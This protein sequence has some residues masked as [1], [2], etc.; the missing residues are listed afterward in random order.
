MG[1]P[2]DPGLQHELW[3][4]LAVAADD[5]P[6][7]VE[8]LLTALEGSSDATVRDLLSRPKKKKSG[9]RAAGWLRGRVV[10]AHAAL[11]RPLRRAHAPR[12]CWRRSR[13]ACARTRTC[14]PAAVSR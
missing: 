5:Q 1:N 10:A 13:P 9:V 8:E 2:F 14:R 7:A 11:A 4:A 3:A 6:L 12:S